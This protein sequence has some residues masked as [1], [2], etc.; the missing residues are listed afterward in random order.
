MQIISLNTSSKLH[1]RQLLHETEWNIDETL[2]VD[3]GILTH[4]HEALS[5]DAFFLRHL[6]LM[7]EPYINWLSASEQYH[8]AYRLY[9]SPSS[10]PNVNSFL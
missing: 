8:P 3:L 4:A 2:R 5:V 6:S 7:N 9:K 1:S 10:I